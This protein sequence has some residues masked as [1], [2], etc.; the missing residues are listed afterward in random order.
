MKVIIN[1]PKKLDEERVF[2]YFMEKSLEILGE[3]ESFNIEI[4]GTELKA[5]RKYR[6]GGYS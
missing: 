4:E 3:L 1:I 2:N 6:K 5:K